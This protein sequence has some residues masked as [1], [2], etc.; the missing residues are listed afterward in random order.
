[1]LTDKYNRLRTDMEDMIEA[2]HEMTRIWKAVLLRY[3]ELKIPM[4]S[5]HLEE[6]V[7]ELLPKLP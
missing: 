5:L 4:P 6:I 2:H 3:E 7:N 1:M